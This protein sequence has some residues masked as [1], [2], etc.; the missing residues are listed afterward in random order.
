VTQAPGEPTPLGRIHT[1]QVAVQLPTLKPWVTYALMAF[2]GLVFIAYL[3]Q[4]YA[5]GQEGLFLALHRN[6][7]EIL[8]GQVWRFL[9]PAFI[10]ASFLPIA[11]N[12]YVL[13][14]FGKG[15]ER[16][17]GHLRLIALFVLAVLAGN[18]TAFIA[19][20][21]TSA[22]AGSGLM[23]LLAAQ[24]LFIDQN[25]F[26][27]GARSRSLVNTAIIFIIINLLLGLMPGMDNMGNLGGMVGGTVFAWLAGPKFSLRPA[28]PAFQIIDKTS[29]RRVLI[30]TA[31]MTALLAL[32]AAIKFLTVA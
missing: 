9:T 31:A 14:V 6:N 11:F 21:F 18:I 2:I 28:E 19:T 25:R 13:Y 12:L 5:L 30:V 4:R 7:A 32:L 26:L 10:H 24:T 27:F 1:Q 3:I 29:P 22:G 8:K 23:G 20:D 16:F 17:Y 15:L